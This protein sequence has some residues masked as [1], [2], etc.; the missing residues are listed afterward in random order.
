MFCIGININDL[1][2]STPLQ[3]LKPLAADYD[4]NTSPFLGGNAWVIK[5]VNCWN[6]L[7]PISPNTL[8]IV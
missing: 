8:Y 7:K 4:G 3:C 1:T 2:M 5:L 6:Q